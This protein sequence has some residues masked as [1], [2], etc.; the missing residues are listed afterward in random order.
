MMCLPAIPRHRKVKT[1]D[2]SKE[3]VDRGCLAERRFEIT[4]K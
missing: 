4:S 3:R 1:D 2:L